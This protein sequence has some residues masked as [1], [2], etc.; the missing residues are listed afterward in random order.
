[1]S[2]VAAGVLFLCTPISVW[3]GDGPVRCAEGPRL[4]IAGIAARELDGTCRPGHPCPSASPI[5]ARDALV[6]LLG[7]RTGQS[8]DGHILIVGPTLRC[9]SAGDGRYGRTAAFCILPDG[10]NLSCAMLATK[11]VIR[12]RQFAAGLRCPRPPAAR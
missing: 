10:R 5:A 6:D 8:R 7:R 9:R 4:R 2:F 12:W 1:M 11:T 3:D